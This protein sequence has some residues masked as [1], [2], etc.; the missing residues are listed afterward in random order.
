MRQGTVNQRPGWTFWF[1]DQI[2]GW[3]AITGWEEERLTSMEQHLKP[4]MVLYDIGVEHGWLSAVYGTFTGHGGMVLVEP[5]PEMWVN[6]R[7]TWAANNFDDPLASFQMF[8]GARP[9]VNP[10]GVPVAIWPPAADGYDT[11]DETP[12]MPYR[13]L[14]DQ[15]VKTTTVDQIAKTIGHPPDAITVDVEGFELEVMFGAKN[16]LR[17]HRPLVWLSVHPDLMASNAAHNDVQELFDY[18]D[19][20]GYTREYLGT[21]HEQHH[22]FTPTEKAP[23]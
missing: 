7:K 8:A 21:D 15:T 19:G 12:A 23:T 18:M 2:A 14:G 4:G 3:D 16:T 9:D 22:F 13:Y 20:C 10:G 17:R 11:A 1:P 5:S 6:I